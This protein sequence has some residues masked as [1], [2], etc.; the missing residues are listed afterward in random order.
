MRTYTIFSNGQISLTYHSQPTGCTVW[1]L[2][3][4]TEVR[5]DGAILVMP[6]VRYTLATDTLN[7]GCPGRDQFDRDLEETLAPF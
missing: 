5:R 4:G 6:H 7:G 2:P 3:T 1:Q